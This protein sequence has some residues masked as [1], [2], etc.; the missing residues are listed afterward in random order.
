MSSL[1]KEREDLHAALQK[2]IAD[3]GALRLELEAKIKS[4][5]TETKNLNTQITNL[6]E[7]V[8]QAQA[9]TQQQVFKINSPTSSNNHVITQQIGTAS[10]NTGPTTKS[11]DSG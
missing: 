9:Q 7:Q 8:K 5:E 1:E 6:K 10:T 2:A 4:G 3:E 11:R